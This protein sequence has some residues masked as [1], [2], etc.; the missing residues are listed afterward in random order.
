MDRLGA[1]IRYGIPVPESSEVLSA[2]FIEAILTNFGKVGKESRFGPDNV[3][4]PFDEEDE[5]DADLPTN[6][7]HTRCAAP[8]WSFQTGEYCP[9]SRH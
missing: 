9:I 2:S 7:E 1:A 8:T 4:N 5:S 3:R 6:Q